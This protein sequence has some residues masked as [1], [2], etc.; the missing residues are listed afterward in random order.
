MHY[1]SRQELVRRGAFDFASE[2][3]V[4]YKSLLQ[5]LIKELVKDEDT[6]YSKKE[7]ELETTQQQLRKNARLLREQKKAEALERSKARQND[8]EYF[9]K[10]NEAN[11]AKSTSESTEPQT[12]LE[13][14]E[15]NEEEDVQ[16][17]NDDPFRS[18]PSKQRSKIFVK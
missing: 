14:E 6:M 13:V 2:D 4:N 7:A 1:Y 5:R 8:P 15:S 3:H 9:K 16:A 11:Q 12:S 17:H 18:F 10:K